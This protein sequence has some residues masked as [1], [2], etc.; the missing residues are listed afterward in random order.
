MRLLEGNHTSE[1]TA[2]QIPPCIELRTPVPSA[3]RRAKE[4][5]L[6]FP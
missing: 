3:Y 2:Q 1:S 6:Y 5:V 4:G